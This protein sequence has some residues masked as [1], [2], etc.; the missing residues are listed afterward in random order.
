[1][2][3]TLSDSIVST[4]DNVK[5]G[6]NYITGSIGTGKSNREK[7]DSILVPLSTYTCTRVW[8]NKKFISHKKTTNGTKPVYE[9]IYTF[10]GREKDVNSSIELYHIF[11]NYI[12]SEIESYKKSN[13]YKSSTTHPM[14]KVN[15]FRT[16]ILSKIED[17]I[18]MLRDQVDPDDYENRCN[19]L[20]IEFN[21]L[22][23]S[24]TKSRSR[25]GY[26]TSKEHAGKGSEI[27]NGLV[28]AIN[29]DIKI[30]KI[31]DK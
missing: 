21:K 10:F 2:E 22:G 9:R 12:D 16:G 24:L 6:D 13:D 25:N 7:L 19:L 11:K 15:S 17:I 18:Y 30:N 20:G 4:L 27:A 1:M 31:L 26:S 3:K 8:I 29:R 28:K 23:I 5:G 14:T